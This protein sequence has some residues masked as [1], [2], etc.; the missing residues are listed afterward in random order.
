MINNCDIAECTHPSLEGEEEEICPFL[1]DVEIKA[2]QYGDIRERDPPAMQ[3][4][5]SDSNLK[6]TFYF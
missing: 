4:L 2:A 6:K 1:A 3:V 5:K